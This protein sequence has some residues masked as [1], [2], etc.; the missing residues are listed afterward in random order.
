MAA[1][2][3]SQ[4]WGEFLFLLLEIVELHLHES[5]TI[6]F[7]IQS[8]EELRADAFL[9]DFQRGLEALSLGLESADL[10]VG[11]REQRVRITAFGGR[12]AKKGQ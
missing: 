6:Q 9:A 1:A 7:K 11:E 2:L 8:G 5:M 12:S 3:L 4:L 10:G